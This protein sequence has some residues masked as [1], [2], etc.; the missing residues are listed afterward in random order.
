MI[1]LRRIRKQFILQQG[2]SDCGV[3]CLLSILRYYD[4]ESTLE[5][6]RKL[7]GTT[8]E[9]TT[10][11]GLSQ[12]AR[13]IGF[14]ADGWEAESVDNLR[15]LEGPAILH[16]I[17][18]KK[19]KHYVVF[20]GFDGDKIIVGDPAKGI[21]SCSKV[22]LNEIWQDKVLLSLIPKVT[23]SKRRAI[24]ARKRRWMASLIQEDYPPFLIGLL[25][26]VIVA[27]L[28]LSTAIFSQKLIDD[29]LPKE[30]LSKLVI[31]LS[32]VTALLMARAGVGY[33]RGYLLA[34]QA[35]EFNNRIFRKFYS[36]LLRLP[37]FFFDTRKT[38]EIVARMN[39]TRRIQILISSIAGNLVIDFLSL[40]VT[41]IFIFLYSSVIGF[42]ILIIVPAYFI[43]VYLLNDKIKHTQRE[44]LSGYAMTES[45]QIDAMEGIA[46][47]KANQREHFFEDLNSSVNSFFQS[48][49]FDLAKLNVHFGLISEVISVVMITAVFGI[50]SWLVL[51]HTV[52]LGE[53][54]ALVGLASSVIPSI[55]RLA[56]ANIQIQEGVVAFDRMFEFASMES[57]QG[58]VNTND[59]SFGPQ[60]PVTLNVCTLSFQFPGRSPILSDVS[61][62]LRQGQ[63]ITL[64]GESGC[65]KS[66]LLQVLQK[67]YQP[68][69]GTLTVNDVDW[70]QISSEEWRS[71]LGVVEQD[72]K[73]F[74]G[75]LIFNITLTE[76]EN[77][78][79]KARTFCS[80]YEFDQF[81]SEYPQGYFTLLGKDGITLSGGQRQMVALARAL[82]KGPKL[83]L[84]DEATAALDRNTE[85]FV[86]NLL[87]SIKKDMGILQVTHRVKPAQKSDHVYILMDGKI[88]A[89]GPPT[90]LMT[91][92]N[93]YS[94]SLKDFLAPDESPK[95][96]QGKSSKN[97][98]RAEM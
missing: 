9:G 87:S 73:I 84:L 35:R 39:D 55:N 62:S 45:N 52:Q 37:K 46:P 50:S 58:E 80:K 97:G 15:E 21:V 64:L 74:N 38:G 48:R 94:E 68:A 30:N 11:L 25:L 43:A 6:L 67:F 92:S 18:E 56:V 42:V 33:I 10:L 82:Y 47:I 59:K 32:L 86:L 41:L 90:S 63:W 12:A 93:L 4:G 51:Q 91:F 60:C 1:E 65:G 23:F 95:N 76:D 17:I 13:K 69:S 19:L 29:I 49:V 36:R 34:W 77:E 78:H 14:D 8:V 26:G 3:A 31:S 85:K 83:L 57:D 66:T 96:D 53:M 81:F 5:N 22:Q 44:A 71:L 16:I 2:Q 88:A 7:S 61:F 28:G 72:I 27:G 40:V 89:S 79:Q 54:V 70:K 24:R 75:T 98:Q 20:Y